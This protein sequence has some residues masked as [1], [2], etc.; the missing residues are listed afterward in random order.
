MIG[1]CNWQSWRRNRRTARREIISDFAIH[2]VHSVSPEPDADGTETKE[3]RWYVRTWWIT[4]SDVDDDRSQ[5]RRA[6][7]QVVRWPTRCVPE[8]TPGIHTYDA[9]ST[10][11]KC[12]I[13][14]NSSKLQIITL[15]RYAVCRLTLLY[16]AWKIQLV[17]WL[18]L[19]VF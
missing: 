19:V 16:T 3:D 9:S 4:M 7:L 14:V 17:H 13:L 8:L 1:Y 18:L 11:E 2:S 6:A 12:H 15:H 10:R 5:P